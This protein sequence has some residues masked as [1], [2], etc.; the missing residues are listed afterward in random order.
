MPPPVIHIDE[1]SSRTD[2]YLMMYL[3]KSSFGREKVVDMMIDEYTSPLTLEVTTKDRFKNALEAMELMETD[4]EPVMVKGHPFLFVGSVGAS[5]NKESLYKNGITHVVNWSATAKCNDYDGIEYLC[6]TVIR[7]YDQMKERLDLLDKAVDFLETARKS[8][9]KA[10]SHCWYGRNR[11][12]TLLV[13]YLMKYEGMSLEEAHALLKKTRPQADPYRDVIKKYAKH[14]LTAKGD[15]KDNNGGHQQQVM[16]KESSSGG[17]TKK[18]F[19]EEKH[20]GS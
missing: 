7:R 18:V 3:W 2:Q 20:T 16:V 9:G 17:K 13:A 12:V 11:S 6:I 5:M 1:F 10:M 4:G 14:Y 19:K 15:G 8:G